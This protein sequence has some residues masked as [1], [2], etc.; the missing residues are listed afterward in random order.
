MKAKLFLILLAPAAVF[1]LLWLYI[2]WAV[3]H[4]A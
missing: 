1:S 2:R 3:Y 4:D